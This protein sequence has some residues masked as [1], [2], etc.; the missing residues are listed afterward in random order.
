MR[1]RSTFIAEVLAQHGSPYRYGGKGT[2]CPEVELRGLKWPWPVAT[3]RFFDCSGL[4][5]WAFQKATGYEWRADHECDRLLSKCRRVEKPVNG[6]LVFYGVKADP[7]RGMKQDAQHVVVYVD[8]GIIGANGGDRTTV[9]LEKALEQKARVCF[10]ASASYRDDF[11]G[12]Y[13]LPFTDEA[14]RPTPVRK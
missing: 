8:G 10:R 13:E 9:T 6:T 4:V 2:S 7:A 5:T 3:P 11:L 14:V 1:M 12:Y